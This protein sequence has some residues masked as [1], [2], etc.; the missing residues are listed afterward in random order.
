MVAAPS[1]RTSALPGGW[2]CGQPHRTIGSDAYPIYNREQ[3]VEM[4]GWWP[5]G[6]W[7][8]SSRTPAGASPRIGR[9]GRV[10]R[11]GLHRGRGRRGPVPGP[12]GRAQYAAVG[13]RH[14]A[15][16]G[17]VR[18]ARRR[19]QAWAN[20]LSGRPH[21]LPY[22]VLAHFAP[23][24]G[25]SARTPRWMAKVLAAGVGAR[26]VQVWLLAG[27]RLR[28]AAIHPE[29]DGEP[30]P[31]LSSPT[32]RPRCLAGTSVSSGTELSCWA[33]SSSRNARVSR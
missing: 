3:T 8:S 25:A 21:P 29:S 14:G 17:G 26:R 6:R 15:R 28:L 7:R 30:P 16:R 18:P 1:G 4:S 22:D 13:R 19:L 27:G 23:D 9:S 5:R 24:S 31:H 11:C 10:R 12:F 20:R 33:Y 32:I 2:L